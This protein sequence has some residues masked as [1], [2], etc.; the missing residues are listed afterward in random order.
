MMKYV[1]YCSLLIVFLLLL[2]GLLLIVK[3]VLLP[4]FFF[5]W[6]SNIFIS[7]SVNSSGCPVYF[8]LIGP[9][10]FCFGDILSENLTLYINN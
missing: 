8:L 3:K 1:A 9:I 5:S 4:Q 6:C 7:A 10:K 2:L